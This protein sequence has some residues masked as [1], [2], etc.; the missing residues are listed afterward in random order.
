MG[1]ITIARGDGIGPEIMEAVLFIMEQ[2]GLDLKYDEIEVGE[3]VFE[4]GHSSGITPENLEIIKRNR[5]LL[6]SPITTPQGK[7]YKSLNVTI[8]KAF[9]LFANIRP[10]CSYDPFVPSHYPDANMVIVRENEEDLYGGIEYR[11]THDTTECVKLLSRTGSERIIRYAF[12]YAQAY[13]RKKVTALIKDN[14]MK[15][16]DGMFG[17][18]FRKVAEEFPDIATDSANIDIGAA[19]IAARPGY[20]DVVVTPNLYGDIVSDIAAEITGSVGLAPSA[21]IGFEHSMF[22]AIHGTAPAIAGQGVANPSGL[23]LAAVMML[24]H[25]GEREAAEKIHNAWLATIESCI[26]TGDISSSVTRERVGTMDFARAVVDH[27]GRQ[28]VRLGSVDY[29]GLQSL[30]IQKPVVD[31]EPVKELVG[32]DVFIESEAGCDIEELAEQVKKYAK[33]NDL[34]L[35]MIDC[36]GL[37][38]WPNAEEATEFANRTDQ[39]RLR[40]MTPDHFKFENGRTMLAACITIQSYISLM[41][42]YAI[43]GSQWLYTYDGVPGF[44]L[45][46][47][48]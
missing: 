16:T 3:K 43:S 48:Q 27:F 45:S 38:L 10:T 35:K 5:V 29:K 26:H 19:H 14:I 34:E 20:F 30:K 40:F 31:A 46:Q 37:L 39:F 8:R 25:I 22:E 47:G 2:A 44:S 24:N 23:L 33:D 32:I 41:G 9:G 18:I 11:P 42:K 4:A 6:K 17:E 12:A 1:K 15:L 28:V 7:G 36:R 21:N 13:G